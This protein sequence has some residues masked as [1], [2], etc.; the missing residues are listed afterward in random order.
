MASHGR[1]AN[2]K[3]RDRDHR[4]LSELVVGR[5]EGFGRAPYQFRPQESESY[6][7]K[8]LTQ[9]GERLLWGKDL[10]RA[11]TASATQPKVGNQ[12][13]ARRVGREAVTIIARE[14][15]AEGRVVRQNEQLA[16]RQRWVVEKVIFFSERSKLAHRVRDAQADV[17]ETVRSHPELMSTFLSL[18]GA[19]ELA[20]RRIADPQDRQ[21][22]LA[23]VRE[24]MAGSIQNGEPLPAVK[25]KTPE[26]P[27]ARS[28][29]AK[30]A[31]R[32]DDLTR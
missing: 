9:R 12:I 10:E 8:I 24:A 17:R 7:M 25:L 30:A 5:L 28:P 18:R 27:A 3:V 22:F 21:R 6:Y 1:P 11:L 26:R 31:E 19:Q 20:E 15:D 13:G 29:S 16:H 2:E 14:R 23:L 32:A 4:R